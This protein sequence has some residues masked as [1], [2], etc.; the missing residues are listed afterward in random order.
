[1]PE[2]LEQFSPA[3][4]NLYLAVTGIREDGF[5][6]LDSLVA[7]LEFGDRISAAVHGS[8]Q[9]RFEC[10]ILELGWDPNNLV[11][12]ALELYRDRTGFSKSLKIVLNKEIPLGA[13]LG[14][15]SSNAATM[16]KLVNMLNGEKIDQT[17][18]AEWST[19]LGSDCRI[20]FGSGIQ[21]MRGRGER[22]ESFPCRIQKELK[23]KEL[24]II[25]PGF[26]VSAAWAY[27]SMRESFRDRYTDPEK[28][29]SEIELWR[30]GE[31]EELSFRNDLSIPID[32]K[33]AAIPSLKNEFL[34]RFDK[35]LFMS[36]SGSA[37]FCWIDPSENKSKVVEYVKECWGPH[38]LVKFTKLG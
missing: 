12:K 4:I 31:F 5:H 10:N 8:G 22:M 14:G 34:R 1:M 23:G 26:R 19:E 38:S 15:G 33:Y 28:S 24:L 2:V 6:E 21:R 36:G 3:K 17:T 18:L 20:F 16:L 27:Q 37:C 25:H 9:D 29:D 13:G 35:P 7:L 11:Y 30:S 32:A